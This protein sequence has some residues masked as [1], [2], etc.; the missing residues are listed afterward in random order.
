MSVEAYNDNATSASSDSFA[1]MGASG[2]HMMQSR[3][4]E[5][6]VDLEHI[7]NALE[8]EQEEERGEVCDSSTAATRMHV[9]R[10]ELDPSSQTK[11]YASM[12]LE[13]GASSN[14]AVQKEKGREARERHMTSDHHRL[15]VPHNAPLAASGRAHL[16]QGHMKAQS[17][18]YIQPPSSMGGELGGAKEP[19]GGVAPHTFSPAAVAAASA[20]PSA[21][22][23]AG[24]STSY[25][26]DSAIGSGPSADAQP[27][28]AS[29]SPATSTDATTVASSP[30]SPSAYL[31]FPPAHSPSAASTTLSY[32]YAPSHLE[33][34]LFSSAP[35]SSPRRPSA[36]SASAHAPPSASPSSSP[37]P[38]HI[39]SPSLAPQ[40]TEASTHVISKTHPPPSLPSPPAAPKGKKKTSSTPVTAATAQNT[41][42]A[43]TAKASGAT[44]ANSTKNK[45]RSRAASSAASPSSS[46]ASIA[47]ANAPSTGAHGMS[48]LGGDGSDLLPPVAKRPA[49]KAPRG[50]A[51]SV[52]SPNSVSSPSQVSTPPMVAVNRNFMDM[53]T[54]APSASQNEPNKRSPASQGATATVNAQQKAPRMN[55]TATSSM[56]HSN[57]NSSPPSVDTIAN[58][59]SSQSNS[60]RIPPSLPSGYL[61][62]VSSP[63]GVV[64]NEDPAPASNTH[65]SNLNAN[66]S[67]AQLSKNSNSTVTAPF[68]VFEAGPFHYLQY[69]STQPSQRPSHPSQ[70]HQS[71]SQVHPNNQAGPGNA[72]PVTFTPNRMLPS[73]SVPQGPHGHTNGSGVSGNAEESS[74]HVVGGTGTNEKGTDASLPSEASPMLSKSLRSL[75]HLS[76]NVTSIL[77]TVANPATSVEMKWHNIDTLQ[78]LKKH[79]RDMYD[80]CEQVEPYLLQSYSSA[81]HGAS[82][83][84]ANMKMAPSPIP[85]HTA[86]PP[87]YYPSSGKPL[88]NSPVNVPNGHAAP[89]TSAIN[90]YNAN[91]GVPR[92]A[93]PGSTPSP[94][95]PGNMTPTNQGMTPVGAVRGAPHAQHFSAIPPRTAA[96]VPAYYPNPSANNPS[97]PYAQNP[98]QQHSHA[99]HG[100]AQ[101]AQQSGPATAAHPLAASGPQPINMHRVPPH[102]QMHQ[103]PQ[104]GDGSSVTGSPSM[105]LHVSG[106]H[107]N[108]PAMHQ[109]MASL[110]THNMMQPQQ[111]SM[112]GYAQGQASQNAPP[113]HHP[114]AQQQP[115]KAHMQTQI[116]H[117][118]HHH[119]QQQQQQQQNAGRQERQTAPPYYHTL[120]SHNAHSHPQQQQAHLRAQNMH[121]APS[122]TNSGPPH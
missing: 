52:G 60:F 87:S 20:P 66:Q 7:S 117:Q 31:V 119:H 46:I 109:Q 116:Q 39:Y 72:S 45:K 83:G 58:S 69:P 23:A 103:Q 105:N 110:P 96:P 76:S 94:L 88:A 12:R 25:Y 51:L 53:S 33:G 82:T 17:T 10:Q 97:G 71:Q 22:A 40:P 70:L 13:N 32:T 115:Q 29:D 3:H 6:V 8:G 84:G 59:T 64:Q 49:S 47:V 98:A 101:S 73:S 113:F 114:Y 86:P 34:P 15:P 37:L 81:L 75:E 9:R 50:L 55:A 62:A 67:S 14:D 61:K 77:R 16:A 111:H 99:P 56:G 93:Y 2:P 68:T 92:G 42:P 95:T 90:Y 21:L 11:S 102:V 63:N 108:N 41:G 79:L 121:A 27:F 65:H 85:P 48:A 57:P 19:R 1:E 43:P 28:S 74:P 44:T 100:A 104:P 107:P 4:N 54:T 18:G 38:N 120:S 106:G 91:S 26:F 36:S 78:H 5:S 24:A 122:P 30:P 89:P 35:L 118:Y 112:Q 80:L